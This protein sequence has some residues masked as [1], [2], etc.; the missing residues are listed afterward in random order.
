MTE[1][2]SIVAQLHDDYLCCKTAFQNARSEAA[3][4][5]EAV[6]S[7]LQSARERD[8]AR[9]FE[10]EAI[11]ADLERS[12][13]IRGLAEREL[14]HLAATVYAPSGAEQAAFE[15]ATQTAR[16]AIGDAQQ[17]QSTIRAALA[18]LDKVVKQIRASTLGDSDLE[19][20]PRWIESVEREFSRI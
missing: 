15:A 6:Q 11:A 8:A 2:I 20:L 13:T 12:P 9:Q 1:A 10:L 18:D 14:E 16:Q 5:A 7:R 3:A 17:I 19:L 4:I